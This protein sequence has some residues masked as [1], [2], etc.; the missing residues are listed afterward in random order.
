MHLPT[1]P[2][3]IS[4][5]IAETSDSQSTINSLA[6]T[7]RALYSLL[8]SYLYQ[9][10]VRH[11]LPEYA[12]TWAAENGQSKTL[13]NLL[14]AG[15]DIYCEALW[16]RK[17]GPNQS[18]PINIAA[19]NGRTS[20]VKMLLDEMDTRLTGLNYNEILRSAISANR[21][22]VVKLLLDRGVNPWSISGDRSAICCAAEAGHPEIAKLLLLDG[23]QRDYPSREIIRQ[24]I[25]RSLTYHLPFFGNEE[26]TRM[27]VA[28]GADVN[29]RNDR[30][31]HPLNGA[32]QKRSVSIT[33][34]LLEAGANPNI[35]NS[36]REGPLLFATSDSVAM[37]RVAHGMK[38][39]KMA[40]IRLL[41]EYG[42]DP[43]RAGGSLALY[44]AVHDKD[45][46]VAHFLIDKGTLMK[47]PEFNISQQAAMDRAVQQRDFATID[48]L[49][50]LVWWCDAPTSPIC[51]YAPPVTISV[52]PLMTR[53]R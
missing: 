18:H 43:A 42:A 24:E 50:Y 31:N 32:L 5:M 38:D 39:Q 53:R 8:N 33:K 15:A 47:C 45:Y 34:L 48:S 22:D 36:D 41:F 11:Y 1:L 14:K 37:V 49:G 9:Y 35:A 40:M 12:L 13:E 28:S 46:E 44:L 6:Q 29:F 4:L 7:N 2:T 51:M 19:S 10:H 26:I 16:N 52:P 20:I 30:L 21:I 25:S 27:L 17:Y 3:E 23:E